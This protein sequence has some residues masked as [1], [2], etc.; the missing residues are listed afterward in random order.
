MLVA[1]A[2]TVLISIAAIVVDLGHAYVTAR[3]MQNASDAAA[4]AGSH[5]LDAM[6][7]DPTATPQGTALKVDG[8]VRQIA[9]RN[10]AQA[11]LVTCTWIQ[12]DGTRLTPC[13]APAPATAGGVEV[14]SGAVNQADFSQVLGV[15]SLRLDRVAAATIQPLMGQDAPLLVCA[16]GQEP[17]A[18]L[19]IGPPY[20]INPAAVGQ[21]YNAHGNDVADCSLKSSSWK[22]VAGVGPFQLPGWLPLST[23]VKAGPTRTQIAGQPGCGV[24]LNVNGCVLVLPI[25]STGNA[26]PGIQGKLLCEVWGA[27]K[28]VIQDA[29]KNSHPFQLMGRAEAIVGIGGNGSPGADD[30]R[31]IRLI[32]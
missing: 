11:D 14:S 3:Q 17:S 13:S 1:L 4:M 15:D 18:P 16:F 2:M 30:V 7:G 22:G 12:W 26:K 27:F 23:G 6:R 5:T 20:S 25:C 31:L 28:L 24:D 8:R 19:L 9:V 29:T 32:R 10:G 21:I